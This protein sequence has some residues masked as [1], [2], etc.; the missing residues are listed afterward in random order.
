[1]PNQHTKQPRRTRVI[2]VRLTDGEYAGLV[3]EAERRGLTVSD[4]IRT[5]LKF[6]KESETEKTGHM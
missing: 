1:M 4:E 3:S 6:P 5:R 2:R